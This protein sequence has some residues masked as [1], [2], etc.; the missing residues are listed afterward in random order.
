MAESSRGGTDRPSGGQTRTVRSVERA[1]RMMQALLLA[2]PR[3]LRVTELSRELDLHKTTVVRLLR[4]LQGLNLLRKDEKTECYTWE[5]MTWV[6]L[7]TNVRNLFSPADAVQAVLDELAENADETALLAYPEIARRSMRVVSW[8]SPRKAVRVDPAPFRTAP[9]HCT[10]AGKAYLAALPDADIEEW[11]S[12][13]LPAL[14]SHTITSGA[15]FL[16]HLAEARARGWAAA[17][18][19]CFPQTAG[20]GVHVCDDRGKAV[21][22]LQLCTLIEAATQSNIERWAELLIEASAKLTRILYGAGPGGSV[23]PNAA[24]P[25]LPGQRPGD[26]GEGGPA[27]RPGTLSNGPTA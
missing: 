15:R 18:E 17:R 14:T 8:A 13:G 19:E 11:V 25:A 2:A 20:V 6:S 7:L 9:M 5:P 12:A 10:A 24:E 27:P 23:W 26:D 16:E 22:G 4:T 21:G 3:G 1:A